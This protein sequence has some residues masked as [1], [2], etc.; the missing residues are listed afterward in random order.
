MKEKILLIGAGGHAR[1][2]VDVIE[3]EGKFQ[4]VGF[5]S[6]NP[7]EQGF[8][9]PILGCDEDLKSLFKQY[10]FALIAIGQ[11]KN[12]N[13]RVQIYEKLKSIG[14][15]LPTIIS[16]LA[17]VSAHASIDKEASIIMHQVL[18]NAGA[19]VGKACI[20]NTKSLIEHDAVVEDFCHIST[21]AVVNGNCIVKEKSFLGSNTHLKH[22][23]IL[24][25]NSIFYNNLSSSMGG[26]D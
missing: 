3:L 15:A 23:Q 5:V 19:K 9:Y 26:G 4:I 7:L 14:F 6:N 1:S 25:K 17:H 21:A 8:K 18:V 2:C 22:G 12:A 10:K 20:L 24:E 13:L 11:I 16:P